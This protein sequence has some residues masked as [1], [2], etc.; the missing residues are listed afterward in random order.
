M[1]VHFLARDQTSN[2]VQKWHMTNTNTTLIRQIFYHSIFCKA[3]GDVYTTTMHHKTIK[4][5]N[6]QTDD[7]VKIDLF[8]CTFVLYWNGCVRYSKQT[9]LPKYEGLKR[10]QPNPFDEGIGQVT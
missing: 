6:F 9:D 1:S 2:I 7:D 5:F 3:L 8:F 10:A 4:T